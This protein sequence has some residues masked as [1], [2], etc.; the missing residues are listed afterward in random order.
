MYAIAMSERDMIEALR[1]R[2][3]TAGDVR[4]ERILAAIAVTVTMALLAGI[5]SWLLALMGGA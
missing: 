1:S 5:A 4:T 3:R 2:E